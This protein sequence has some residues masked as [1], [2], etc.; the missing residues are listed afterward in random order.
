MRLPRPSPRGAS[1]SAPDSSA[2]SV[3][4][5]ACQ[6]KQM[7]PTP[8]PERLL[9]KEEIDILDGTC[10]PRSRV[11]TRHDITHD[12]TALLTRGLTTTSAGGFFFIPYL[13]H[14]G[15]HALVAAWGPPKQEGLPKECP[16]LG[17]VFASIFGS[18]AGIRTVDTVSRADCGLLAGLPFLPSPSTQYR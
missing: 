3:P 4:T 7:T 11:V 12:V 13:P 6:K 16:A 17:L 14:R 8:L 15:P 5:M 1:R 9:A 10:Q 18:P 2:R